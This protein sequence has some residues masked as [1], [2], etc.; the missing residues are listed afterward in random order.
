M[1]KIFSSFSPYLLLSL[2]TL[3]LSLLY[4]KEYPTIDLISKPGGLIALLASV[5]LFHRL[6][7]EKIKNAA[8]KDVIFDC[9]EFD[10]MLIEE[11]MQKR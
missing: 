9:G 4:Q 6:I 3:S 7:G 8:M 11:Q 10:G 2:I 5:F 1:R